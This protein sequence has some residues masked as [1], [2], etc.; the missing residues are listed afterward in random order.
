MGKTTPC[1][2]LASFLVGGSPSCETTKSKK[3]QS[4]PQEGTEFGQG[5]VKQRLWHKSLMA[6]THPPNQPTNHHHHHHH[7]HSL[8]H[9]HHSDLLKGIK[10][11]EEGPGGQNN[12][13]R[14]SASFVYGGSQAVKQQKVKNGRV[15]PKR[16]QNLVR[17][18]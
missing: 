12:P 1:M 7:H 16:K 10:G 4:G 18:Q 17:G 3:W 5:P 8:T 13:C 9:H 6:T 11:V 15:D 2:N 14:N